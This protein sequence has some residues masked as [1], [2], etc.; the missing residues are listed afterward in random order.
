M[1]KTRNER[2]LAR[3]AKCFMAAVAVWAIFVILLVRGVI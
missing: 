3:E 1:S 2:K